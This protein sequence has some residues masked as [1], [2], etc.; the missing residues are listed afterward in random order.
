MNKTARSVLGASLGA[1][2]T[3]A[4]RRR[5]P[6][7]RR[8]PQAVDTNAGVLRTRMEQSVK[9]GDLAAAAALANQ[10]IAQRSPPTSKR[11]T[12]PRSSTR[13]SVTAS[14]RT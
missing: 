5:S 8:L 13:D 11:C 3:L 6:R 7:R 10:L 12:R 1:V 9:Q 14:R 2:L 4:L